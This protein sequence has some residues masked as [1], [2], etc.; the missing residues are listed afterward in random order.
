MRA[1][2]P[3]RERR[4]AAGRN[5]PEVPVE[6]TSPL[7]RQDR[8]SLT[9][10]ARRRPFR[11]IRELPAD[12]EKARTSRVTFRW[13]ADGGTSGTGGRASRA[14][15]HYAAGGERRILPGS[16]LAEDDCTGRADGQGRDKGASHTHTHS[17]RVTTGSRSRPAAPTPSGDERANRAAYERGSSASSGEAVANVSFPLPSRQDDHFTRYPQG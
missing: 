1:V 14:G 3:A 4:T 7:Q 11:S 15:S 12:D 6:R 5:R 17:I 16:T 10:A 9:E 8:P 2:R 13:A